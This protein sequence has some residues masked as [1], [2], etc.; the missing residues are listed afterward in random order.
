MGCR[1]L[2][3]IFLMQG[4]NPHLLHLLN[5][6][7][8]SLPLAPSGKPFQI[9]TPHLLSLLVDSHSDRLEVIPPCGFNL[10]FPKWLVM[11]FGISML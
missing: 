3:Q 2:L 8:G 5:W 6:Q 4:W 7:A 11:L 10:H 1:A 9:L